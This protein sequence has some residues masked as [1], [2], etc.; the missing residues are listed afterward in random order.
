MLLL[1]YQLLKKQ[2]RPYAVDC[3]VAKYLVEEN[4]NTS[5]GVKEPTNLLMKETKTIKMVVEIKKFI[6]QA[7]LLL[8]PPDLIE[9]FIYC[10]YSLQI[11]RQDTVKGVLCDGLNWHCFDL[12]LT[13]MAM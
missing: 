9:L 7:I 12:Q 11:N 5:D 13:G 8:E 6:G 4:S 10:H 1:T 2:G 3:L